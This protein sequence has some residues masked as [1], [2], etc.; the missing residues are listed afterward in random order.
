MLSADFESVS[1]TETTILESY[2]FL[3]FE[4]LLGYQWVESSLRKMMLVEVN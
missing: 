2:Y 4:I 3:E 1:S